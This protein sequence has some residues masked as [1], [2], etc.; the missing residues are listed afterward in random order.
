ML[1]LQNR[2]IKRS[3]LLLLSSLRSFKDPREGGAIIPSRKGKF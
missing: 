1:K 2:E 3:Y